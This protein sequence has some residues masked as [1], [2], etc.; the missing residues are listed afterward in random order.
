MVERLL[1]SRRDIFEDYTIEGFR[2][3]FAEHFEVVAETPVES[4][5]R[6]VFHFRRR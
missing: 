6:T 4:S 5:E 2:A 3:A 1:A